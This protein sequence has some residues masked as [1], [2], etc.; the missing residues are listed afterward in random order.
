MRYALI[1]AGGSGTRLWPMSRAGLPKHLLPLIGG[2]SLL[3]LAYERLEGLIPRAERY[4]CSSRQHVRAILDALPGLG[5]EQLLA[6]PV[7]RDT[8][9]AAGLGAA[10]L[11]RGDP[12]AV[13]AVLTADHLIEPTDR[14]QAILASAFEL[15]E[16]SRRTL[17]TF[18][19]APTHAATAYGYLEMGPPLAAASPARAVA[20][21]QEKP[22]PATAARYLAAGPER[23]LWNSGMFV[24]RAATLLECMRRYTP[25]SHAGLAR[26]AEAWDGP[27][28]QAVLDEVYPTLPKVS[29]DYAVMEPASGDRNFQVA[30]IPMPLGWR[31][32]GS[33]TALAEV[34]PRDA[35]GNALAAPRHV[36]LDT[37]D[38]LV[39]TSDP[40]HLIAVVGCENLVIVHTPDATLVCRADRAEDVKQIRQLVAERYG[41]AYG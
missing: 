19:I 24:W 15:A 37:R 13:V 7:G 14:F 26:I 2:R 27:Q 1:L 33:W 28:R 20:R 34:C 11:A 4:V 40:S 36:L 32:V 23:Y 21:F 6:E 12:E 18:G 9:H 10:I 16:G 39:A 3:Q 41:D 29:V 31:D 35:G 22:D 30:A 8:L 5:P 25:A 17:L 38:T